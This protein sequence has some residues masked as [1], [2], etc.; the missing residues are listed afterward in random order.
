[1]SQSTFPFDETLTCLKE[2]IQAEG[3]LLLHEIDTQMILRRGGYDILSTR[4]L[5]FFHPR[6]MVRLLEADPSAVMEAPLRLLVM[7]MPDG[8]VV[9]RHPDPGV[10]LAPYAGLANLGSELSLLLRRILATV[11]A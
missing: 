3:L 7:E 8:T 9:V 10:A 5:F 1:M 11:S 4:Q 6:Y 2:A